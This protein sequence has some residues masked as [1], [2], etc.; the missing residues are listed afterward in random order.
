MDTKTLSIII[1][2]TAVTMALAMS[3]FA[4]PAF[5][6]TYLFFQ[7][8]EIPIVTA[9]DLFS[10]KTAIIISVL[11]ASSFNCGVSRSDTHGTN[12]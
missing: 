9:F 10:K 12:L 4:V 8:W 5:F 11:N 6:A 3:G 7:I 1:V 2:F